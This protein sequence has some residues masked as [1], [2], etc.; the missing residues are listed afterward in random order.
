MDLT[1]PGERTITLLAG[2]FKMTPLEL[3]A[4]TTYPKAKS[5]RLPLSVCCYTPLEFDITLMENDLDW[6]ELI[7][8][9]PLLDA[10]K[11]QIIN[12][13]LSKLNEWETRVFDQYEKA[14]I[15]QARQRIREITTSGT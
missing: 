7:Q 2:L 6:L 5:D 4:G 1:I 12:R 3:V 8:E 9:T 13:W 11:V 14:A 10:C 15:Q